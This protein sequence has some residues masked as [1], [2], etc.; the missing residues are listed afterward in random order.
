MGEHRLVPVTPESL[1]PDFLELVEA[2]DSKLIEVVRL[3]HL[4]MDA[5]DRGCYRLRLADG[6]RFKYRRMPSAQ[7]ARKVERL[8]ERLDCSRIPRI[9][10]RRG[11]GLLIEF[12]DGRPLRRTDHHANLLDW[13]GRLQG[14]MHSIET[15]GLEDLAP[16][17]AGG[18]ATE[19]EAM[20]AQLV[21]RDAIQRPEG[22]DL[23]ALGV[24]DLRPGVAADRLGVIHRDYCAENLMLAP[25]GAIHLVDNE[26]IDLGPLDYDLARTWYRWPMTPW[27][28]EAFWH[29]YGRY[30]GPEGFVS[31]FP[32]WAVRVMV[33]S[34]LYR[35]EGGTRKA[36][37]PLRRLRILLREARDGLPPDPHLRW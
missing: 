13:C 26:T 34:A 11:S 29:G 31:S 37:V 7:R 35:L 9:L 2:L 25:S 27:E 3:T 4:A 32:Y 12:I 8:V 1:G 10:A 30:R 15:D 36:L 23:L 28:R 19:L 16:S 22:E 6:R 33:E 18:T 20:V 14:R 21:E 5:F 24:R 17:D